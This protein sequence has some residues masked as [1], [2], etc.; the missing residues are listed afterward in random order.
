MD[1]TERRHAVSKALMGFILGKLY[2]SWPKKINFD[3][4]IASGS[5][6]FLSDADFVGGLFDDCVDWLHENGYIVVG[7][8]TDGIG[9][10]HEAFYGVRLSEKAYFILGG[11]AVRGEKSIGA[12]LLDG[13]TEVSSEAAKKS[14]SEALGEFT[15]GL[16]KSLLGGA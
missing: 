8:I 15:G 14:L 11:D 6:V 10:D 9:A 13:V 16:V 5:T 12:K 7:S 2:Q 4:E 1:D 3:Y